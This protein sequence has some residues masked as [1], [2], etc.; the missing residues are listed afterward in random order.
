MPST[1]LI[2]LLDFKN[3]HY[4]ETFWR[5]FLDTAYF[6]AADFKFYFNFSVKL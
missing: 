2:D 3:K 6:L 4:Q 5:I 1:L